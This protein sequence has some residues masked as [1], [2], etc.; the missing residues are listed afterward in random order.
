MLSVF[1]MEKKTL[2][3]N[4]ELIKCIVREVLRQVVAN[5]KGIL[6]GLSDGDDKKVKELSLTSEIS[7]IKGRDEGN[8]KKV[9]VLNFGVNIFE[10]FNFSG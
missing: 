4:E 2:K 10:N 3:M 6:S 8:M 7:Q 5:H 1:T 9:L